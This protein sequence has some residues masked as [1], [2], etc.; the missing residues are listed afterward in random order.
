MPFTA[1]IREYFD[2]AHRLPDYDG[3]CANLHGHRWEVEVEVQQ[4]GG[5]ANVKSMIIDFKELKQI[6]NEEVLTLIDHSY[7]NDLIHD[8]TAENITG[9]I[10]RQLQK[11]MADIPNRT[12]A[13]SRVRLY[14]SPTTYVEWRG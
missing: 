7:L 11:R 3:L 14:E 6:L 10:V 13:L 9:W 5:A 4:L 2:A 1:T 12:F 8:P